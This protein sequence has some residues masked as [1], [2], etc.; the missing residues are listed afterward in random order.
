MVQHYGTFTIFVLI[1]T[2]YPS[3]DTGERSPTFALTGQHAQP[4]HHIAMFQGE[5]DSLYSC[6]DSTQGEE[7]NL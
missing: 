3:G 2:F 7:S 6:L 1:R 4:V 5:C